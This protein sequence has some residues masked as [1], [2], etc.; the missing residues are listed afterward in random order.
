M[1]PRRPAQR[2]HSQHL[3]PRMFLLCV[4]LCLLMVP[5]ANGQ[6]SEVP[7][8]LPISLSDIPAQASAE[9]VLLEQSERLLSRA[10]ALDDIENELLAQERDIVQNLIRL[11]SALAAASSREAISEIE[12]TWQELSGSLE[13]SEKELRSR[14]I[15][16]E[17]QLALASA[18]H[19]VWRKTLA[20]AGE[21]D[22]PAEIVVLAKTTAD[23]LGKIVVSLERMRDHT[24]ALQGKVG[25]S[26]TSVQEALDQAS[27]EETAL[28]QNLTR[29]ERPPLWG[30]TITGVSAG[31]LWSRGV[32]EINAW[33]AGI[34]AVIRNEADRVIFQL[35]ILVALALI[36]ARARRAAIAWTTADPSMATGM[37]VFERPVA[38]A[39]LITLMLTPWLYVSTPPP[40]DDA[41][42]LLLVLPVLRLML[43][44]LDKP[45]R[46]ALYMLAALY[47][48][49]WLRD[50]VEAAPLVARI[51]FLVELLG[52]IVIIIWLVRSTALRGGTETA[53][54]GPWRN[55]IRLGLD[56]ALFLLVVAGLAAIAGFVRLAV[57]I[58]SGVLNSAYLALLLTALIQAADAVVALGLHSRLGQA[59]K[60]IKNRAAA[61][62][63]RVRGLL[64]IAAGLTWLLATLDF[65]ALRDYM[66]GF[67]GRIFFAEL[68][69]GALAISLADVLA[70]GLTI[71]AALLLARLITA[72]LDEDVYTR[73]ELGR[74]VP[75]AI[76]SIVK[77]GIV[78]LGFVL[79]V[80][81]MGMGMDRIT[82]LLGALGVGLGFGLQNVVNNFVSGLILIFERPVQIGDSIEVGSVTGTIK[83]LGIRS[84]TIRSFEG[85]DI[86][87]PNGSL[88]SD[89]LKNW[90]MSDRTR[91]IEV[92]VGVAYGS[93]PD[94][95]IEVLK[96]SLANEDGLLEQP[97][98]QVLFT[99]FGD[100]S[101]DFVLR[102]W[103]ADND[104][105][106]K[107]RSRIGL[108]VNRG[109]AERG[110]E[111]PFP[112][113][114]L[115]VRSVAPGVLQGPT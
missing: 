15:A 76:S 57:L 66:L 113:R 28:L 16:I 12:Q 80:G 47:V 38:L 84:S 107:V 8:S 97:E 10:A 4:I 60:V 48:I 1:H 20:A 40:I 63:I 39:A 103:V 100:S 17:Q 79:A 104:L 42:G 72:I 59:V 52:A 108:A 18:R 64:T 25:R 29:R 30:E 110:I 3:H 109:L 53:P 19:E 32:R 86:T 83:R 115:H 45:V 99:G 31:E 85:A 51:V 55:R 93:N 13:G 89:A 23:E 78:T 35:I 2:L 46:P 33:W 70:F 106:V 88:L 114:D 65:F 95:V 111:I 58:G 98:P 36:L 24:L 7:V 71:F 96:N 56:I 9:S 26:R 49:D 27:A 61:I 69:A 68:T 94:E 43:P 91:R 5:A 21:S 75:F 6:D 112:Q 81:A 87:I 73:V 62:R 74:G 77:Y 102:A 67:V 44:L 101:L 41:V 54:S 82:I 14:A 22:A 90:T 37:S 34:Y 92:S 50:L 11:K 105:F